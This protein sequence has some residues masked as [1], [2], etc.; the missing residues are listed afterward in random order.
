MLNSEAL[1]PMSLLLLQLLE[2]SGIGN[3]HILSEAGI[4]ILID[5]PGVGENYQVRIHFT[6]FERPG[7]NVP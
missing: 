7:V 5:L 4:D 1:S 3:R 2:L 6:A